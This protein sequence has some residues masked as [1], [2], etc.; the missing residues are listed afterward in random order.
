[1]KPMK[2]DIF[3]AMCLLFISCS[4]KAQWNVLTSNTN[5]KRLYSVYCTDQ[6]TCYACGQT[7]VVL[8][9]TDG[10]TVWNKIYFADTTYTL[11]KIYFVDPKH[12]YILADGEIYETKNAGGSWSNI[13]D[14]TSVYTYYSMSYPA[15][16]HGYIAANGGS[17]FENIDT[18]HTTVTEANLK[19]IFFTDL[20]TGYV[21]S[22]EGLI[23]KTTDKASF[24]STV[25]ESSTG[26]S[27]KRIQFV[28]KD[29]GFAAG[30][31][32]TYDTTFI[33]RTS[34]AG[35]T[36]DTASFIL[37]SQARPDVMFFT[38]PNNGYLAGQAAF[39]S[40]G[41]S[42]FKTS[43]GGISWVPNYTV[44]SSVTDIFFPDPNV[45]YAV[46]KDGR[47]VKTGITVAGG[48]EKP[49]SLAAIVT[50]TSTATFS[51]DSVSGAT[52]YNVRY[53][54]IDGTAWTTVTTATTALDVTGLTPLVDNE[55]Q[56]ESVCPGGGGYSLSFVFSTDAPCETP[57]SLSTSGI[58]YSWATAQWMAVT[59]ATGYN[60][61]YHVLG[62]STWTTVSNISSNSDGLA[63]LTPTTVYEFK[64]QTKCSG[65]GLSSYGS[66]S[67]FTTLANTSGANELKKQQKIN[68][69][70]NPSDGLFMFRSLSGSGT[71]EIKTIDV[72]GNTVFIGSREVTGNS[73]AVDLRFL[74]K[75][76]YFIQIRTEEQTVVRKIIIE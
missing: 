40:S 7:G 60:L 46:L 59:G 27:F 39:P 11:T 31:C 34:D 32:A 17:V 75:G 70:P 6:N 56:V 18:K 41:G 69:Y 52:G 15:S 35:S 51:W 19:T 65:G 3:L 55:F 21:A 44:S 54:E 20:K 47:I 37:N 10:G 8:K 4:I 68:I 23:L 22:D 57:A 53:R 49:S 25:Y 61:Q 74:A 1:M 13:A 64:V 45:G 43:D 38:D 36:W 30:A 62:S 16:N 76:V 14:F 9:T 72:I 26:P 66:V 73:A 67:T 2:K 48:C 71:V 33:L 24:W 42:I 12:G 63:G 28:N 29:T 58:T 50:S 5:T